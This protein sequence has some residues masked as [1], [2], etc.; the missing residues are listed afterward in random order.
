MLNLLPT[1]SFLNELR[2]RPGL[3]PV[4]INTAA[5]SIEWMDLEK[6]HFYEGFFHRSVKMFNVLKGGNV[7]TC[8]T[9]ISILL[10]DNILTD[11]V[12]PTA[13]IFHAGRCGSTLLAKILA[14]AQG[15]LVLSE[16]DSLNNII[17]L[18]NRGEF[19]LSET[20]NKTA[21]RNLVLAI[22]R[23]RDALYQ[24]TII[25]FTSYNIHIF[26]FIHTV[27]PDVPAIFLT[28]DI[29]QIVKSCKNNMPG[30]LHT[31]NQAFIQLLTGCADFDIESIIKSFVNKAANCPIE[32]LK[33]IAYNDLTPGN[34]PSVLKFLNI[35]MDDKNMDLMKKQFLYDA[36]KDGTRKI[37]QPKP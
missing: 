8:T 36:K 16:P 24:N 9:S 22:A 28:R 27:F 18:L 30:W 5:Q 6:Y 25:K 2:Q 4:S 21:Y 35:S 33:H 3:I 11:Y 10:D 37:F 14:R 15:N 19:G 32:A 23:R 1:D 17:T 20:D 13:F 12:Y 31:S 29:D 34:L 26:D 7:F